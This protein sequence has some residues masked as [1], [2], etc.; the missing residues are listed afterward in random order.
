MK[1]NPN[2]EKFENETDVAA[3]TGNNNIAY[4]CSYFTA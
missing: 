1:E 2:G 3:T 4:L